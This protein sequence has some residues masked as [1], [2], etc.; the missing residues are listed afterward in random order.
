M[1]IVEAIVLLAF[2]IALP[3]WDVGSDIALSYS[4][5]VQ[6]CTTWEEYVWYKLNGTKPPSYQNIGTFK[7]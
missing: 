6:K 7:I 1:Q 3:T 5:I 4:F 2:G